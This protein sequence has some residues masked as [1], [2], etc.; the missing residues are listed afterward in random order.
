MN[1][2]I[3]AIIS[4]DNYGGHYEI[5]DTTES[6]FIIR[7][8]EVRTAPIHFN[9]VFYFCNHLGEKIN[10]M[11]E[12][13]R[14]VYIKHTMQSDTH[15]TLDEFPHYGIV[16]SFQPNSCY[17]YI[18][19][20]KHD[21]HIEV[22]LK[23]IDDVVKQVVCIHNPKML[24]HCQILEI[25]DANVLPIIMRKIDIDHEYELCHLESKLDELSNTTGN[26]EFVR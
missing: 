12:N 13:C 25:F 18:V 16:R 10:L 1:N 21:I 19:N 5:I 22:R 2:R 11:A 26:A 14:Y 3:F 24:N 9:E 8:N 23:K 4:N 6:G 17:F 20:K 7:I 15:K